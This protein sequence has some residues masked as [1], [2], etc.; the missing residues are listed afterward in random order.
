MIAQDL[1]TRSFYLAGIFSFNQAIPATELNN[2]LDTLNSMLDS[3]KAD[4]LFDFST[5]LF[6]G[7]LGTGQREYTIGVSGDFIAQRPVC[8]D[9]AYVRMNGVDYPMAQ[10]DARLYDTL[11]LKTLSTSYPQYFFYNPTFPN[12]TLSVYPVPSNPIQIFLR[13]AR[14]ISFFPTLETEVD[15]PPGY[16]HPI[17]YSLASE[18][19]TLYGNP[20]QDIED[21]AQKLIANLKKNNIHVEE[22]GMDTRLPGMNPG[23]N[24]FNIFTGY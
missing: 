17:L 16:E 6:E 3:W 14:F 23:S 7:T 21:K 15:F 4:R 22:L 2:G 20:R 19:A 11:S 5:E 8:I 24:R 1:I 18:F 12:G 9:G 10:I 13:F